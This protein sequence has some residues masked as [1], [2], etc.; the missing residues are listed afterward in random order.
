MKVRVLLFGATADV[1]GS[2]MLT[3]DIADNETPADVLK[4]ISAEQPRLTTHR[5]LFAVNEEH[6]HEATR[7][8]DGDDLAIFTAVSGG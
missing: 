5:L 1:V 3:V 2:K 6:V 4:R 7:L 8:K